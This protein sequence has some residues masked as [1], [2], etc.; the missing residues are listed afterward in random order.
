M[1]QGG[2]TPPTSDL[3]TTSSA[4]PHD[5]PQVLPT[6]DPIASEWQRLASMDRQSPDFLPLLLT[7]TAGGNQSP[8]TK[9]RGENARIVLSA[10]DEVGHKFTVEEWS[11]NNICCT[12]YQVF[13]DGRI[14]SKYERDTR[15]VMRA[16]AH[17]SCQVPPRYQVKPDALSVESRV[18]TSGASSDIRRGRL[19]EKTVAVKTLKTCGKINPNDA[20]KVRV[21]SIFFGVY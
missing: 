19:G 11:D 21:T 14:P 15:S 12:I 7:L 5:L 17:D 13:R 18:F 20:R 16:L 2:P 8:T 9:L 3:G 4:I 10:L 6:T 1:A